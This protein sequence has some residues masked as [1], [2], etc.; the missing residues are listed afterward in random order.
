MILRQIFMRKHPRILVLPTQLKIFITISK[1]GFPGNQIK[2]F[3]SWD[4]ASLIESNNLFEPRKISTRKKPVSRNSAYSYL[5]Q[6]FR[7][8]SKFRIFRIFEESSLRSTNF[9]LQHY[10][11]Y[12]FKNSRQADINRIVFPICLTP[13][14]KHLEP[15]EQF[16][17]GK[18]NFKFHA[19]NQMVHFVIA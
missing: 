1:I 11:C 4:S 18:I 10:P 5:I 15:G 12:Q 2:I 8:I 9:C 17:V 14:L 7:K 6:Q 3:I 16:V 19:L 13:R